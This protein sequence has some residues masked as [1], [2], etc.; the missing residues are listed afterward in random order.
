[1][2][3]QDYRDMVDD[4][5]DQLP[6]NWQKHLGR[7]LKQLP[8]NNTAVGITLKFPAN[9]QRQGMQIFYR[10]SDAY[11]MGYQTVNGQ[12]YA[13]NN[14]INNIANANNLGFN[15]DYATLGWNRQGPSVNALNGPSVSV[16]TLDLALTSAAN[17]AVT[18]I[19]LCRIVLAL[20]EGVRFMDVEKA[21]RGGFTI[22]TSMVDWNQQLQNGNAKLKQG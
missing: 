21:V 5:L 20:A 9:D 11:I 22:D 17:G 3:N 18:R 8:N 15:D 6:G 7:T 19:Q 14:Q 16:G 10:E 2:K 13:T 12:N 4:V 1:M